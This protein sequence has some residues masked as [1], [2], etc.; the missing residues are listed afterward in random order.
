MA[1]LKQVSIHQS[2]SAEKAEHLINERIQQTDE[3]VYVEAEL[4]IEN[5]VAMPTGYSKVLYTVMI[6][7]YI[8][9]N[10]DD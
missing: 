9:D 8:V 3:D 10:N 4:L 5:S 1:R 2:V 6:S 7:E